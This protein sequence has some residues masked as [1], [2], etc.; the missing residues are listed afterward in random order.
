MLAA[1]RRILLPHAAV[2]DASPTPPAS[3]ARSPNTAHAHGVQLNDGQV[4]LVREAATSGA[5]VQLALA[6]AGTGKTTAMAVL[7]AAW[8][9]VRRHV[10]GLAPTASAAEVLAEDLGSPHRHHRQTRGPASLSADPDDARPISGSQPSAARR[11]DHRRR[12]RAW[13]RPPTSTR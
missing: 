11:S 1:E 3:P 4:A 13:P 2:A 7:A 9:N 5:R 6:P 12:S 8:R 10:I